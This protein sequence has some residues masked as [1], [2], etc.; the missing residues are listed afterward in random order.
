MQGR[1]RN[2]FA[3]VRPPGHHAE[4]DRAMGFCFFNN[5]AIAA[6]A[7]LRLGRRAGARARLGRAP[8]Q[9]HPGRVLR[10]PR[11]ALPVGAPVPVLPGHRRGHRDRHGRGRGLHG[12]R[13]AAGRP[14]RRGLRRGLPRPLPADRRG[15]PA[16]AGDRL[17]RAS[18]RTRTIRSA[19]WRSPSAA[20]RRWRP[21]SGASPS[22]AAA[23]GSCSCSR[24]A[25]RSRGSRARRTPASRCSGAGTRSSPRGD[26]GGDRRPSPRRAAL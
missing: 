2:A 12:E 26:L 14:D 11:R 21:R 3:L 6:E 15:V 18:T 10:P 7:A 9:R 22:A 1:A 5:V 16:G 24:A 4:P 25:T 23:A 19:A 20:S 8:R 13:A 17:R